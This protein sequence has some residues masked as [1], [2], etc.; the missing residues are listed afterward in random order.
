MIWLLGKSPFRNTKN[1][2]DG[3]ETKKTGVIQ[4]RQMKRE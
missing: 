1:E 4:Q 2:L 3:S